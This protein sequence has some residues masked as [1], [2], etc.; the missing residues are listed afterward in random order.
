MN[1]NVKREPR[2]MNMR[3]ALTVVGALLMIGSP[4]AFQLSGL[5]G[6]L[7]RTLIVAMELVLLVVGFVLLYLALKGQESSS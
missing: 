7:E 5:S 2:S 1:A 4:Y 6:R 3:L